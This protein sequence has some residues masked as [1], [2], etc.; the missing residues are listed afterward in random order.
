MLSCFPFRDFSIL[1]DSPAH[2]KRVNRNVTFPDL[3]GITVPAFRVNFQ[4]L[5][6]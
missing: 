6:A 3:T 5:H 2:Y 4:V 1:A